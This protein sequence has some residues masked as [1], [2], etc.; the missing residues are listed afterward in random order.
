MVGGYCVESCTRDEKAALA[1][2]LFK[3]S[4]LT[5]GE[6]R[7]C[8]RHQLGYEKIARTSLKRRVPATVKDDVE[9]IA[10]WFNGLKPM[11]GYRDGQVFRVIWLDRAFTLYDHG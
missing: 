8:G 6:L 7:Q 5:W 9:I 1:E 11:V 10:F 2:A 4:R 3:R